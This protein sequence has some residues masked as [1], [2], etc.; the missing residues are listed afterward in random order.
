[1]RI[2]EKPEGKKEVSE[3]SKERSLGEYWIGKSDLQ[4]MVRR[5]ALRV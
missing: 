2:V 5:S 3:E 4:D 1:V